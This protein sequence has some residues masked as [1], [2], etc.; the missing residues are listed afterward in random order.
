MRAATEFLLVPSR[1]VKAAAWI[2]LL[3][4]FLPLLIILPLSFSSA[5]FLSFPPPGL[6]LRWYAKLF[7][8]PEW[9]GS[10]WVSIQVAS[11]S[12]AFTLIVGTLASIGLVRVSFSG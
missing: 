1:P 5:Q 6:S 11:L 12:A 3:F 7:S 2:A 10:M 8:S 9:L 4:L